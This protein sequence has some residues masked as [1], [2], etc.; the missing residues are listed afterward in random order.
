MNKRTA[1]YGGSFNPI[2]NGHI[3]LAQHVVTAGYADEVWFMVSPRNPLKA[4]DTL[5]PAAER[6]RWVEQALRPY[7][8]LKA[9]DFEFALPVP[10]YTWRT[11]DALA[12]AYPNR[13]FVWLVGGDNWEAFA[14]WARGEYIISR[15]GLL[16]YPRPGSHVDAASLPAGVSVVDNAPL[17]P[18]SATQV[19]EALGAGHDVS[20]MVPAELIEELQRTY[21][22]AQ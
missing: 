12:A 17:F 20:H 7:P 22:P 21:G 9:S 13:H 1:I 18:Y 10:S 5:R 19:R 16:I 11:L 3:A 4:G 15:Y 14:R 8:A 2:H 6:L